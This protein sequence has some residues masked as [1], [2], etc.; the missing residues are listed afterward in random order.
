MTQCIFAHESSLLTLPHMTALV[1]ER[2]RQQGVSELSRLL[3]RPRGEASNLLRKCGM[4]EAQARNG[5]RVL[6]QL[7]A[8]RMT[9]ALGREGGAEKGGGGGNRGKGAG[10]YDMEAGEEGEVWLRLEQANA[11]KRGCRAYLPKLGSLPSKARDEGW[12][13][14]VGHKET[15]ELMALKRI[16]LRRQATSSSL[17][18]LA[19][20]D[21][22]Q[23][24][25]TV[26]LISD[27]YVGLDVEQDVDVLLHPAS[28]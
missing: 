26:Y 24:T 13:A 27:C 8:I 19:P 28:S 22:G 25:L 15:D 16:S 5:A 20:E 9:V 1:V 21:P 14:V 10:V 7:P 18:F 11:S 3:V 4:S 23:A 6:D 12:W 17:S 2:L